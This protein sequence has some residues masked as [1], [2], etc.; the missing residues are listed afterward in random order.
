MADKYGVLGK[1]LPHSY[2]PQI[3][4]SFGSYEYTILERSEE[5]VHAIF[6]GKEDLKGFNVTIPYKKLA[7]SLCSELSDEA[8]EVGAVNTVVAL[9]GGGFKGY[10]TDVYGFIYMLQRENIEITGRNCLVL[11]T[12]GASVAIVYALKQ[13]GAGK[14]TL[15]SRSGEVNYENCYD[16]C[17][18]TQVIVNTTPVG[19]YPNVDCS[20]I[21]LEKFNNLEAVADIV[22]NPSRTKL[23][24]DA[25]NLGLKTS[26]GLSMLVAQAYKA[27]AIFQGKSF[28]P[29]V[30]LIEKVVR[31]LEFGMLNITI[32]GMPGSGKTTLGKKLAKEFGKEFVD[33]DIL[34][35]E[36]YKDTPSN[37]IQ[38]KGEDEFRR[39]E[40]EL[41]K[42][43]LPKSGLVISTGGGVVTR[44]VNEFFLKCNSKVIYLK[45]PLKSLLL[46]DT[47]NRPM[48]KNKGIEALLEARTPL[49]EKMCDIVW[50]LPDFENEPAVLDKYK[51]ELAL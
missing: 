33:L 45:R 3:H 8:R 20:P 43:Y 51:K 50:D 48:S 29:N 12:G 28:E 24:Q 14:I 10:N 4:K 7:M 31:E 17:A 41:V 44:E 27:A 40:T 13:L 11:G 34:F 18:D 23:L 25:K 26:G 2:S 38:T 42:K 1:S 30:E 6:E 22:Y 39:M 16:V 49:Y 15:C 35:K 5:Q 46:Q 47:S 21:V 32:I 36:E 9:P 19:M 37:I